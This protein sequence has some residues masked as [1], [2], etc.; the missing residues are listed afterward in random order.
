MEAR[1]ASMASE[2]TLTHLVVEGAGRRTGARWLPRA[3]RAGVVIE[4]V[5]QV[6][7]FA[8]TGEPLFCIYGNAGA[9]DEEA[10]RTL[11]A[12][13]TERTMEQDPICFPSGGHRREGAVAGDQ[14][15]NHRRARH[16]PVAP[17][18]AAGRAAICAPRDRRRRRRGAR[19][20]PHP[21]LG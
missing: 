3:R 14:R 17:T 6:G 11:A 20:L 9:I 16:R 18:V 21:E 2:R 1:P 4:L 7:D 8:A 12:F 19:D 5:P 13:G 10:L 15:S